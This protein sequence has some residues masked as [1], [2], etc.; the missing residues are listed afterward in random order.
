MSSAM[1]EQQYHWSEQKA[2]RDVDVQ[3][4]EE[5]LENGSTCMCGKWVL[6]EGG[7]L[8]FAEVET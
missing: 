3:S 1:A 8:F 4:K 7:F 5:A 6:I 2:M